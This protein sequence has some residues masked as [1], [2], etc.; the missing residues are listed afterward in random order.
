MKDRE[1]TK[2]A[3]EVFVQYTDPGKSL[4]VIEADEETP[5]N[6]YR[7]KGNMLGQLDFKRPDQDDD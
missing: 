5:D 2:A 3:A 7:L 4:T 1:R 6:K